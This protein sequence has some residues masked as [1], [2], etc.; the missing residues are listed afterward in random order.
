MFEWINLVIL[1]IVEWLIPFVLGLLFRK[2]VGRGII[3][4]KKWLLNDVV[5]TKMVSIRTY[6]PEETPVEIHN[7]TMDVYEEVRARIPNPQLHDIFDDGMRIAVPTFG[8]LELSLSR[9][10]EQEDMGNHEETE[11]KIKVTLQP[12]SPVRLGVREVHLL[13][14]FSQTAEILFNAAAGLIVSRIRIRKDYAILEFPRF[15]RFVEEKTFEMEDKD[16]GTRV[17]AT[18][19]KLTLIVSPTSQIAKATSKYLL[20]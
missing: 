7:F 19:N 13:N 17:H 4:A 11:E 14:D 15:G 20:V 9:I 5:P 10:S 18:R 3:R 8:T 6:T 16:L 1:K 2:R 12:E